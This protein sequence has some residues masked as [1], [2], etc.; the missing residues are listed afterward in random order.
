MS[1]TG[2]LITG[3]HLHY[4][5]TFLNSKFIEY[6][7]RR[8]YSV[9]LG[10]KGLRWLAQYMEKLPIIQPTK[11]IEQNL[12]KLLDINNYNEIDKFIYHLYNLTNEE[13]ELIEKS[14]K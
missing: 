3:K 14:I 6:S 10:E 7:F 4:L 12:S 5:L 8:F 1:N 2:Y 11:E 9:S 13:I